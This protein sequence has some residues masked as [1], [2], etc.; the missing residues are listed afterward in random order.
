[1]GS[2][3]WQTY[4]T[5]AIL[6]PWTRPLGE[7]INPARRAAQ[8][9]K[10]HGDPAFVVIP[11]RALIS[12]LLASGHPLHQVEREAE[13]VLE[14]VRPFGHFLEDRISAP[15]AFV[16]TLR[17]KTAKFG[18]LDDGTF[19]E[20]SFEQRL[21]GHPAHAI[22]Q[23][24]YWIRKLQARFFAGDY[25]SAVDAADKAERWYDTS[26]ALALDLTEMASFHFYAA[27]SRASHCEPTGPD[28]YARHREALQRHEQHLRSWA[29][30]CPQN[31]R[32]SVPRCSAPRFAR[33]EGRELDA[34]RPVRSR[35]SSPAR[36]HEFVHNEALAYELA[37]RF[38]AARG[39][40]TFA[41]A[42]LREARSC[43]LRWGADGKVRQLDQLHPLVEAARARAGSHGHDRSTRRTA[44]YRLP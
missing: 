6:V 28:P 9:A 15:L 34:E 24:Y 35:R 18:T 33:I 16:R 30:N 42:Y 32:G 37:A 43:Y 1:M 7:G 2:L 22:T 11:L 25:M 26:P 40:A 41:N 27:L 19:T 38:Y 12:I 5:L 23:C 8:M 4:F 21:T 39:F 14:F 44:R 20:H 10:K 13:E 29:A 3:W 17:G 31:F 36:G